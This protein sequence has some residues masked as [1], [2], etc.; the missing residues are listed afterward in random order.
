MNIG[1]IRYPGSN[2]DFDTLKYFDN[3]YF[4]WHTETKL[5]SNINLLIITDGFAFGD[6]IYNK[7]TEQYSIS[8]GERGL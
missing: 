6:R 1:I 5:P 7:A 4:I 8:P 3:S 2:C